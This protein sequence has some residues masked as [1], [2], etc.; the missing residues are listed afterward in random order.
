MKKNEMMQPLLSQ[1]YDLAGNGILSVFRH[2]LMAKCIPLGNYKGGAGFKCLAVFV[3][4]HYLGAP[5][6]YVLI[7]FERHVNYLHKILERLR[8]GSKK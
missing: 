2:Q 8:R 5:V 3:V 7:R 4:L 1:R 6:F